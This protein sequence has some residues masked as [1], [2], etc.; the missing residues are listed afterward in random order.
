MI[1]ISIFLNLKQYFKY[2]F[3]IHKK[4]IKYI[5][6]IYYFKMFFV[7]IFSSILFIICIPFII[8]WYSFF[9]SILALSDY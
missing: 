7:I 9:P 2:I 1:F 8:I 4:N 6:V 5:P 3:G